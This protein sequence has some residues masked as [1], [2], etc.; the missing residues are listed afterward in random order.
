MTLRLLLVA[1]LV[2]PAAG[3]IG[4]RHGRPETIGTVEQQTPLAPTAYRWQQALIGDARPKVLGYVKTLRHQVGYRQ[5]AESHMVYDLDFQLVGRISTR[6]ETRKISP[7][8][9]ETSVG[10][11]SDDKAVLFLLT[12]DVAVYIKLVPMVEPAERGLEARRRGLAALPGQ[13]KAI[14]TW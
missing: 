13:R 3:C 2:V 9:Q 11:F 5:Y 6:G 8:G 10:S 14:T 7:K 1:L 4:T 12:G